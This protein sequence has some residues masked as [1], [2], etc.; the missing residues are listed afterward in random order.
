MEEPSLDVVLTDETN[1]PFTEPEQRLL[2]ERLETVERHVIEMK[3]LTSDQSASI[4]REFEVLRE[5]LKR[6]G[7]TAWFRQLVGAVI[8]IGK[9]FFGKEEAS[10]IW[11]YV[12]ER[13]SSA[14]RLIHDMTKH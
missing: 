3:T 7:R 13:F 12:S 9:M 10:A 1:T 6:A 2:R 5:E 4:H 14:A 8:W 11:Y